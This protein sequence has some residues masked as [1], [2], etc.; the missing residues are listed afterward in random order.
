M[1]FA[2]LARRAK[3]KISLE[4]PSRPSKIKHTRS[5][6]MLSFF[7][8]RPRNNTVSS[9]AATS[10][11]TTALTSPPLGA[12]DDL[13]VA[14]VSPIEEQ[15][16][17][18]IVSFSFGS[19]HY[20]SSPSSGDSSRTSSVPASPT[21]SS[22]RSRRHRRSLSID[23][24]LSP[25]ASEPFLWRDT[26]ILGSRPVIP[27]MSVSDIL[28]PSSQSPRTSPRKLRAVDAE[29]PV[30]SPTRDQRRYNIRSPAGGS[31]RQSLQVL[32]SR[33]KARPIVQILGGDV[34]KMSTIESVSSQDQIRS[35]RISGT[36]GSEVD[37]LS[38]LGQWIPPT[39]GPR[40]WNEGASRSSSSSPPPSPPW[41]R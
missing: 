1:F 14:R 22:P 12:S 29:F 31:P 26:P 35:G 34:E 18:R 6:S 4:R 21:S 2:H 28:D 15:D 36:G 40:D 30:T 19:G 7:S 5:S 16:R 23:S 20:P 11:V 39:L 9:G 41:S 24:T 38:S 17:N 13:D 33:A 27:P 32:S 25:S 3:S 8:R 37:S 10:T